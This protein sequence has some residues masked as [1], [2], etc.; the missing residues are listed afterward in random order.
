M[1]LKDNGADGLVTGIVEHIIVLSCKFPVEVGENVV[2]IIIKVS[3]KLAK[4]IIKFPFALIYRLGTRFVSY[5][6]KNLA[7]EVVQ[8]I[9]EEETKIYNDYKKPKKTKRLILRTYE[10][11]RK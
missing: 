7:P 8:A 3:P 9:V 4:R 5:G 10:I 2:W 11:S 1:V 6:I